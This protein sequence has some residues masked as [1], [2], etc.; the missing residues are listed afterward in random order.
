MLYTMIQS[1]SFFGSG[2][3]DF[4]VVFFSPYMGMVVILFNGAEILLLIVNAPCE[5][6]RKLVKKFQR[7]RHLKITQFYTCV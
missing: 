2:E 1:Q 6:W 5:V 7:R 4:Y 3:E